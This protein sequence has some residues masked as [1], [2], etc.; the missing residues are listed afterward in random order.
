MEAF[1][2]MTLFDTTATLTAMDFVKEHSIEHNHLSKLIND[3]IIKATLSMK[4]E[5][6]KLRGYQETTQELP[7]QLKNL[8]RKP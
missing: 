7:Q 6:D 1:A 8:E 3:K 2:K 5:I 4:K